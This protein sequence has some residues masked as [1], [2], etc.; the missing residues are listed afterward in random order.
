MRS[1]EERDDGHDACQF[2]YDCDKCKAVRLDLQ[3]RLVLPHPTWGLF[4]WQ[5]CFLLSVKAAKFSS[6]RNQTSI[7]SQSAKSL[8]RASH[9]AADVH[10]VAPRKSS[11]RASQRPNI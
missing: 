2:F 5:T 8:D 1:C 10:F 7:M 11:Q 3:I 9:P 4:P 6:F